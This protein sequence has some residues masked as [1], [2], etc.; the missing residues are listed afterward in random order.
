MSARQLILLPTAY[1]ELCSL[2][3]FISDDSPAAGA[4]FFPNVEDATEELL[5]FP[6]ANRLLEL[7]GLEHRRLRRAIIPGFPNHLMIYTIESDTVKIYRAFHA[8][9]D[10]ATQL[11]NDDG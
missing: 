1:D 4:R 10:W 8:A 6:E 2:Q 9:Q 5:R 7:P 11:R 3:R